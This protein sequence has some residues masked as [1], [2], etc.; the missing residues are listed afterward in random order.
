[1]VSSTVKPVAV[2][3]VKSSTTACTDAEVLGQLL[4]GALG[5]VRPEGH[6]AGVGDHP[7]QQ[8]AGVLVVVDDQHAEGV[9]PLSASP[10]A[11]SVFDRLSNEVGLSLAGFEGFKQVHGDVGDLQVLVLEALTLHPIAIM[12]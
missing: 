5:A 4:D 1:M 12:M 8:L 3:F 9:A 11:R 2:P 6:G 7:A 10:L